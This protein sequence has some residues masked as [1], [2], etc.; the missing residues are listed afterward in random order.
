MKSMTGYG[1][2]RY[3]DNVH[4][5][6]VEIKSVNNR[7]LDTS[8]RM[9]RELSYLEAELKDLLKNKLKRGKVSI[10]INFKSL[11]SNQLELNEDNLKSYWN[12]YKKA[13]EIVGEDSRIPLVNILSEP[14]VITMKE[15]D[16]EDAAFHKKIVSTFEKALIEHEKM[17][18]A[19]G[20]SMQEYLLS[21]VE[22]M[23]I[24]LKLVAGEFPKFKEKKYNKM[25]SNIEKI[26]HDKLDDE[27]LKRIMLEAA[28]Y[29]EKADITEEV[30]RFMDHMQKMKT[31]VAKDDVQTGKS[32]NFILQEMHREINTIGSKFSATAIFDQII[33]IK[34]EIEKCREIVQN[35]E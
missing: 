13:A 25:Q 27:A 16:L 19:E 35:V 5:I 32:I 22:T 20:R 10:N 31:Q 3:V 12:L 28:V 30:V 21:A 2:N 34:E 14:N 1:R 24:S 9:P 11:Q 33:I 23:Q 18:L 29:V 6:E 15:A 17:A 7:F 4:E 8:F 26:L